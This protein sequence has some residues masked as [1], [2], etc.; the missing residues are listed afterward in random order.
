[1]CLLLLDFDPT[2]GTTGAQPFAPSPR[3]RHPVA[4]AA[5]RST[6]LSLAVSPRSPTAL[7]RAAC[8]RLPLHL[9]PSLPRPFYSVP[10]SSA[11]AV[12]ICVLLLSLWQRHGGLTPVPLPQRCLTISYAQP[13]SSSEATPWRRHPD[14]APPTTSHHP[15]R[16]T[17]LK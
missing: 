10:P 1:L 6:L 8:R 9:S 4:A 16:P 2:I 13:T 7:S 12:A 14:A 3:A 17:K 11:S 15:L 5:Y